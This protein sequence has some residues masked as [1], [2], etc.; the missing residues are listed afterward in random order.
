MTKG[1]PEMR[2]CLHAALLLA[3]L[4]GGAL[5]QGEITTADRALP[6]VTA[7]DTI[8]T[9]L[10]LAEALLGE[11]AREAAQALPPAPA[12]VL[13]HQ[14]GKEAADELMTTVL[15]QIL[16]ERGYDL[17]LQAPPDPADP[18]GT[19]PA[20]P[21]TDYVLRYQIADIGLEYPDTGRRLGI[22]RQWVARDFHVSAFVNVL[23]ADSGRLLLSD[24][25]QRTYRDRVP[26]SAFPAVRSDLFPF[27]DAETSESGWRNRIEEIVVLGTLTG[28]VAVYFAN[29]GD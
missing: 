2:R 25:L 28:L 21:A 18:A 8:R 5:A 26:D 27:T 7:A 13:L 6:R 22:W 12:S 11:V 3:V 4:T 1:H 17:Y 16:V 19:T 20:S 23:E 29:T 10:F 14:R 24:R 9:N 15:R